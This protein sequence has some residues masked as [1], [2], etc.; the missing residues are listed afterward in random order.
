MSEILVQKVSSGGITSKLHD[1]GSLQKL[2]QD[3]EA[4]FLKLKQALIVARQENTKLMPFCPFL[5]ERLD[6]NALCNIY[7][8]PFDQHISE[9]SLNALE[10]MMSHNNSVAA[11]FSGGLNAKTIGQAHGK[12]IYVAKEKNELEGFLSKYSLVKPQSCKK[13]DVNLVEIDLADHAKTVSCREQ[14]LNNTIQKRN[15]AQLDM[16]YETQL[17][18]TEG[19]PY[20][21]HPT[22]FTIYVPDWVGQ[23]IKAYDSMKSRG[24]FQDMTL[25]EYLNNMA[26]KPE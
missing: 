4:Y 25:T 21:Y 3:T 14:E 9:L 8:G 12:H 16:D 19:I 24:G 22:G 7:V 20:E 2:M 1:T 17:V 15:M 23:A 11:L 6:T 13:C 26:E 10:A 18:R 5:I